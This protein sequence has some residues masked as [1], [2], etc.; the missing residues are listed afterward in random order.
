MLWVDKVKTPPL[1]KQRIFLSTRNT[2]MVSRIFVG[3]MDSVLVYWAYQHLVF[4]VI[5][6]HCRLARQILYS[7]NR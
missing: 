3:I 4:A 7:A 6:E 5:F 1:I 2:V